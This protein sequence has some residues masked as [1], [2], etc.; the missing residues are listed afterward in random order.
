VIINVGYWHIATGRHIAFAD[1]IGNGHEAGGPKTT[2]LTLSK[3]AD[4]RLLRQPSGRR[5]PIARFF[6][7]GQF[8]ALIDDTGPPD[9]GGCASLRP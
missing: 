4:R 9:C 8:H 1:A 6:A 7:I 3:R 5:P 2:L